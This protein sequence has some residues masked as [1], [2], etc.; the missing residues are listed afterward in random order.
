MTS[1]FA[2]TA[3][4]ALALSLSAATTSA[5]TFVS[6]GMVVQASLTA[7]ETLSTPSQRLKQ[8]TQD[9]RMAAT[10]CSAQRHCYQTCRKTSSG[11]AYCRHACGVKKG[12]NVGS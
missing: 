1:K 12:C 2:I 7:N 8:L 10:S 9:T 3:L 6:G 11:P 5:D 4:S